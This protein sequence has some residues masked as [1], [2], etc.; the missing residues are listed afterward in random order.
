MGPG[1]TDRS[2]NSSPSK[3]GL[4]GPRRAIDDGSRRVA[5]RRS[6]RCAPLTRGCPTHLGGTSFR[7]WLEA[8][9]FSLR[10]GPETRGTACARATARA[11]GKRQRNSQ[12]RARAPKRFT[13]GVPLLGRSRAALVTRMRGK[14]L[15]KCRTKKLGRAPYKKINICAYTRV[16]RKCWSLVNFL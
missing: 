13:F 2:T 7:A 11:D 16:K 15:I 5:S 6:F 8:F 14:M 10:W 3:G 9:G 4:K 1:P 12:G